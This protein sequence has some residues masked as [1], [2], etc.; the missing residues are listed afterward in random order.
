MQ[1]GC[2]YPKENQK[3][4]PCGHPFCDPCRIQTC[5]PHI[6][7]VVLYSVE[8][9][10]QERS[11][12]KREKRP[13]PKRAFPLLLKT[14]RCGRD[15]NSRETLAQLLTFFLIINQLVGNFKYHSTLGR[16]VPISGSFFFFSKASA[17]VLLF[18]ELCK[19]FG[20]KMQF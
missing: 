15:S 5:N 16:L 6:R 2:A 13:P 11:P 3:G 4:W 1:D 8:L 10:D 9:M 14:L 7:S 17:K 12:V 19:F 18:F 20:K